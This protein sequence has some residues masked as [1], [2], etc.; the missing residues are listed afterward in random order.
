MRF[1]R[2]TALTLLGPQSR[3]GDILLIFRVF[4]PHIWE[5]GSTRV[6]QELHG[7]EICYIYTRMLGSY[8]YTN[9]RFFSF[10]CPKKQIALF[11]NIITVLF[12]K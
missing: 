8:I 6:K 3:F 7:R 2:D 5:C 1:C 12:N 9:A 4:R 11:R 10:F